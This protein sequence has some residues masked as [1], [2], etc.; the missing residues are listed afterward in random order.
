MVIRLG[1]A[2]ALLVAGVVGYASVPAPREKPAEAKVDDAEQQLVRDLRVIEV[3]RGE[4]FAAGVIAFGERR[5]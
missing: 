5:V 4:E 2:A 1:W 3:P